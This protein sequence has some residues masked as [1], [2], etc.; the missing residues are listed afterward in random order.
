M[1]NYHPTQNKRFFTFD[2]LYSDIEWN[3]F[4]DVV[5]A[6]KKQIEYWYVLPGL[7]L[8]RQ[9][10]FGFSVAALTSLLIDCL[11]QYEDGVPAGTKIN[12]KD[13]LRRHWKELKNT[14]PTSIKA[15]YNGNNFQIVDG[16]DAIYHGLRCGILHEAHVKLYTGLGDATG[17]MSYE[18]KGFATYGDGTECPVV[19]IHAGNLFSSVHDRF[20]QYLNELLNPNPAYTPTREK[21]KTKFEA[22][23]GVT[24]SITL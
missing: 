14:F 22:S 3:D 13:F 1:T 18:E 7:E 20:D 15:T 10:H 24:I 8:N 19:I 21:F 23:Y 17:I 12:F 9:V 5:K 16:A 2:K 6:F 4:Q 11:S